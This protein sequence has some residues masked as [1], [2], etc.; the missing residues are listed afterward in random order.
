MNDTLSP[1]NAAEAGRHVKGATMAWG[2][3]YLDLSRPDDITVDLDDY[4][5]CLAYTVR[6][7]GQTRQRL[8]GRPRRPFFG[9][10]QHCVIGAQQMLKEGVDPVHARA[11]LFHESDEIPFGDF[12]GPAKFLMP[13]AVQLAKR[14]GA[15]INRGFGVTCPDPDLVKR[16]DIRMLVTEKRDLMPSRFDKDHFTTDGTNSTEGYEPFAET[17]VPYGDPEEAAIAFLELAYH[18]GVE[19]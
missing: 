11:F 13:D 2:E 9:V 1:T 14:I 15:S 5:Y 8:L 10:G 16:Y 3:T 18:L 12:P 4:A 6:W 17:I 7:R 19:G